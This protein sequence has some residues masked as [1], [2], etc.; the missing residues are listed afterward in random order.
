MQVTLFNLTFTCVICVAFNL[1]V[2]ELIES[3]NVEVMVAFIDIGFVIGLTFALFYIAE[4]ITSDLLS[5][6]DHFYNSDWFQLP[7]RQQQ[8][9]VL[10]IQR[11]QREL[12][13]K[14]LGLFDC[15]LPVF[16]SVKSIFIAYRL[17]SIIHAFYVFFCYLQII[18]TAGSYYLIIRRFK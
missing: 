16:T 18:R 7:V 1:F 8:L 5:V 11:A 13:F 2:F 17:L 3:L 15:S 6:G 4:W 12:R 10:P 9:L 14:G